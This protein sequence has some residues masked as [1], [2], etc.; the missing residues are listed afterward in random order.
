MGGIDR[1]V[2]IAREAFENGDFRWAAT[3]LDHAV[4]TDQSHAA[5][6]EL[7]ADTLEQLGYGAECATWRNFFLS[8]CTELRDGNFGTPVTTASPTMLSQLTPEQMF[9]ILAL[10]INGPQA[11]DI[12]IAMDI[13]FLDLDVNY[14]VTLRNGVLVY[15]KRAPEPE[16]AAATVSLGSKMRLMAAVFGDAVSPG[17]EITGDAGVLQTLMSVLGRPDPNFN[18]I[19][20]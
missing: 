13:T 4:F 9:D 20:P 17:L 14:R 3:L 19:T 12:D 2:Q 16:T 5:A 11:W 8:G 7:Y 6:R 15:R 1:V 18:I 10:S